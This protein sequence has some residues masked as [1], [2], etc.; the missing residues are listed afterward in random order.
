MFLGHTKDA[1]RGIQSTD[2]ATENK[3][4]VKDPT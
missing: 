1:D 3:K 2:V 4:L